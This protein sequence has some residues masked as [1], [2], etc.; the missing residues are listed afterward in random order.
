M[1]RFAAWAGP[2]RAAELNDRFA[3]VRADARRE[4]AAGSCEVSA[5]LGTQLGLPTGAIAALDEVYERWDGNGVPAGRAG[6]ELTIAARIVHVAERAVMAHYDGGDPAAVR[7]VR[8]RAGG[9]LDPDVCAAFVAAADA[10]LSPLAAEDILAQARELEPAPRRSVQGKEIEA[11]CAA[12]GAFADL[13]GRYLLGHASHVAELVDRAATLGGIAEEARTDLRLSALLLDLG[14]VGVSSGIWDRPGPLG[15]AEWSGCGCTRTGPSGSC[16]AARGLSGWRHAQPPTTNDSTGAA[17]TAARGAAS[18]P[19][20][21]VC[22][23][24]PTS[25]PPCSRTDLSA[26]AC[27]VRRRR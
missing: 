13:K 9:Q 2:A 17:I 26:P 25:S 4:L 8:R 15:Q 27:R 7:E 3:T 20:A 10:I 5:G 19:G 6:D 14:R 22:W 11:V 12:F 1:S 16:G 23:R 18:C 21:H 24:R